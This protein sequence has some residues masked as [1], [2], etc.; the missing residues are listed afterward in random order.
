MKLLPV[1]FGLSLLAG[2][3]RQPNSP[4]PQQS[5]SS[6]PH[7]Y[8]LLPEEKYVCDLTL[9]SQQTT[10]I[11]LQ[12]TNKVVLGFKSDV[13]FSY[14]AEHSDLE[15]TLESLNTFGKVSSG[16]GGGSIFK[17]SPEGIQLEVS[18]GFTFPVRVVIYRKDAK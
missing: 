15:V 12:I 2:C 16:P 14:A 8:S 10:N 9:A 17:G 11:V 7:W 13:L 1:L 4:A 5:T 3:S 18:S 6:T